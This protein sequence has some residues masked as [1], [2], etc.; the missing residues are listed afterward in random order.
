MTKNMPKEIHIDGFNTEQQARDEMPWGCSH[1]QMVN[2][3]WSICGLEEPDSEEQAEILRKSL[4]A[5][6]A[7]LPY[8]ELRFR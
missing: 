6:C 8:L 5:L 3:R 2:G 7:R 4:F 1:V